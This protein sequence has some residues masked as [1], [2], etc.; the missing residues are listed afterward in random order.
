MELSKHIK[1]QKTNALVF[2]EYFHLKVGNIP[3]MVLS[4]MSISVIGNIQRNGNVPKIALAYF[5][6][7]ITKYK[8]KE[9]DALAEVNLFFDTSS[10]SYLL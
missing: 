2:H 8:E 6:L 10:T 3:N 4:E 9:T 5:R 1:T 7:I